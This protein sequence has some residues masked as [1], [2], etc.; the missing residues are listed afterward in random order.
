MGKRAWIGAGIGF[1][2][3]GIA[4]LTAAVVLNTP[5]PSPTPSPT[6]GPA[7]APFA[8]QA[9]APTSPTGPLAH[10]GQAVP[11]NSPEDLWIAR[12]QARLAQ[13]AFT[14]Q[15][16]QEVAIWAGSD[17]GEGAVQG[18]DPLTP[19]ALAQDNPGFRRAASAQ[20][21]IQFAAPFLPALDRAIVET[22]DDAVLQAM[23]AD[24]RGLVE[25]AMLSGLM[26]KTHARRP[27]ILGLVEIWAQD[28]E[29]YIADIAARVARAMTTQPS[30]PPAPAPAPAPAP[31]SPSP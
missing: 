31:P 1:V 3:L 14:L 29:P 4:A 30:P 22:L 27:E 12:M 15:D 20:V 26:I 24:D 25:S 13:A 17:T 7:P 23:V 2:V 8:P 18:A 11:V 16:A 19:E 9:Q 10:A 6:P 21:V 28:S 5:T